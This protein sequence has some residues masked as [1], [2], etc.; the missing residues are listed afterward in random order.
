M[1]CDNMK[2]Y[3]PST[4]ESQTLVTINHPQSVTPVDQVEANFPIQV[5][6]NSVEA[7]VERGDEIPNYSRQRELKE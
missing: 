5:G 4:L 2:S 7:D 1:T 3:G 6:Y